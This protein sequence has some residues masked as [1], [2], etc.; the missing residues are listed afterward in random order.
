MPDEG[1]MLVDRRSL[2]LPTEK[3]MSQRQTHLLSWRSR[4][5]DDVRFKV[6]AILRRLRARRFDRLPT[7]SCLSVI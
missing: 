5:L 3:D 6:L 4:I 1:P 2:G 7:K